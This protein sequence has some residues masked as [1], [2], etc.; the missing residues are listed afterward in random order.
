[1]NPPTPRRVL[2]TGAAGTAGQILVPALVEQGYDVLATDLRLP[3]SRHFED[4]Q[5]ADLRVYDNAMTMT[6]GVDAVVHLAGNPDPETALPDLL[7]VDVTMA[8]NLTGAVRERR[9]GTYVMASSIHV[10]GGY[11]SPRRWP[12]QAGWPADPCCAYGTVKAV[13][14][15]LALDSAGGSGT[16]AVCLRL[17]WLC[18]QPPDQRAEGEW[19]SP[20]DFVGYVVAALSGTGGSSSYLAVSANA[21]NHWDLA[22]SRAGLGYVARDD[23]SRFGNLPSVSGGYTSCRLW[24]WLP[25]GGAV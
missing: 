25:T 3:D 18:P 24:Q 14:E 22:P 8:V 10:L 17:G 16:R 13:L 15:R 2:V 5:V 11:N 23:A 9:V 1:M 19:L 12:V 6:V 7:D 20:R 4:F 21:A